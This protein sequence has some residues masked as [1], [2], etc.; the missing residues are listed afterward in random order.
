MDTRSFPPF[1]LAR[2]LQTVFAPKPGE[3][4]AILIDLPEPKLLRDFVF[5]KDPRL[6]IQRHAYEVFYQ[7]LKDGVLAQLKL[8]GGNIFAYQITGGSNLDLPAVACDAA[9]A[10]VRFDSDIYPRFDIILC[11][12]TYSATA[13]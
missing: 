11:I 9:G 8:M 10:E 3:R 2:L 12:S 1:N 13:P 7:G 5:L 4:V 6:T